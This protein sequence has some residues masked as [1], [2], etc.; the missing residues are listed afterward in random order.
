MTKNSI[1]PWK[2]MNVGSSRRVDSEIQHEVFW[3]VDEQRRYGFYLRSAEKFAEVK[4]DIHLKGVSLI[5]R[6]TIEFGELFLIL[7][8]Q[9][10]WE[11]FLAICEDILSICLIHITNKELMATVEDRLRRWQIFL[12]QNSDPIM[13]AE[14][15]M[16]LFSELMCLKDLI[17][18]RC[19]KESI[20]AWSGPDKDKQDFNFSDS[21][22]EVKSY[23]TSKGPKVVISSS[24]Q[25]LSESKP[26][27][28]VAY[29]LTLSEQGH[30]IKDI[31]TEFE[32]L[33]SE[34]N[35]AIQQLF[36]NKIISYGYMPNMKD[37]AMINFT[38]DSIRIFEVTT[39]FPKLLP[40]QIPAEITNIIYT[41]DLE[42]C[43]VHERVSDTVFTI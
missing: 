14:L 23:R 1:N 2:M 31:L 19:A 40:Y 32:T 7:N 22:I 5:K 25:L 38:V 30:S 34:E 37:E 16:G 39:D 10:D 12:A 4:S 35:F 41:I 15:Q 9:S 20:I 18:S 36:E 21:M 27:Y 28:L 13:S 8:R 3:I 17:S 42:L 43:K 24:H 29:G 6:N 33:L 11:L 26:L